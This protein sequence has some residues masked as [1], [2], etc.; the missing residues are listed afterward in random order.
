MPARTSLFGIHKELGA[1]LVD[2][3]G[4][5][6]PLYYKT[7][8]AEH[9][10]VRAASG[11]FDVSHMGVI[12]A[13]G[14]DAERLLQKALVRDLAGMPL[15]RMKL[16]VMCDESG[17]ILDDLTVYKFSGEKFWLVVNAAP[18]E[19]DLEW[20][21]RQAKGLD[22]KLSNLRPRTSKL[23]IQGPN[24]VQVMEAL[25]VSGLQ[26]LKF[27]RFLESKISGTDCVLSRS[28]YTGED[29]FELY[30]P[31]EASEKMWSALMEAGSPLGLVP[32]GLA[33]RDTL[34][35]EA[36]MLLYGQDIDREHSIL[37]CPY[38]RIV[39]WEKDFVGKQALLGQRET[40]ISKSLTG[41]EV[42]GRGI[43]RPGCKMLHEGNEAGLVTS[44]GFSPTL[45]KGIGLGYINAEHA[46]PGNRLCVEVR[47]KPID[48]VVAELPFYKRCRQGGA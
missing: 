5:E 32:C 36:G 19:S 1:T 38:S 15:G 12:L 8:I 17:G 9:L 10:S 30:F 45:K 25:G 21:E 33:A 48:A 28:G 31:K 7:P 14:P 42:V 22:V 39:S 11:L 47:G 27:Y 35:L 20:L 6:M 23:D 43:A 40:V 41:F 26:A 2:F 46:K 44:A 18:L 34:R 29:G 4:W 37:Q 13:E 24:S 16:E 3:H